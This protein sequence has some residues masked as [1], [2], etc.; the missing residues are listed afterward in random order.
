[1][2]W[3]NFNKE[4]CMYFVTATLRKFNP[5][6]LDA[7]VVKIIFNSLDFLRN[8]KGLKIYAYVIMP[9]H[10]HLVVSLFRCEDKPKHQIKCEDTPKHQPACMDTLKHQLEYEDTTEYKPEY[11]KTPEYQPIYGDIPEHRKIT[12]LFGDF[13]RFTSRQI[14][15]YLQ[16]KSPVLFEKC[17]VSAYKGQN[18]AIWQETF[19][20]EVIYKEEFLRQKV[21]YIHMNPVRRGLVKKPDEWENSSFNQIWKDDEE[22]ETV[23]MIDRLV[24]A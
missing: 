20:S 10:L 1:M 15:K 19:R 18:Y 2:K 22:I 21:D 8:N 7:E 17:K 12:V 24:S 6:F 16:S 14:A 4:N 5:L 13:K 9:E 23:F 3:K 11:D